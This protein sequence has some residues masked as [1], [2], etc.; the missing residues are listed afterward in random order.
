[1][2]LVSKFNKVF[3]LCVI[4]IFSK[5]AWVIPLKDKKGIEITNTFQETLKESKPKPNIKWV[6]K[7]SEFYNGSMKS[8]LQ[9]NNIPPG[10]RSRS[11]APFRSH[12]DQEVADH[13]ETSSRRCN[14]YVN[15]KDL[16]E[17]PFRRLIGT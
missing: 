3:F 14:W 7:D 1:M 8:S 17:M 10:M 9:S 13:A 4:D 15:D 16:F 2:Q 12:I 6:D 5:Y 11:N